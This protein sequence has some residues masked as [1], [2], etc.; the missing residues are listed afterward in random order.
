[1]PHAR[2]VEQ[3]ATTMGQQCS[4]CTCTSTST[5][6]CFLYKVSMSQDPEPHA[7]FQQHVDHVVLE[8]VMIQDKQENLGELR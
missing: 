8:V 6:L 2:K 4:N 1:M 5:L 3:N 7:T